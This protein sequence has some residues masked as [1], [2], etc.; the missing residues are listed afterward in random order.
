MSGA[1]LRNINISNVER[2][3][4]CFSKEPDRNGAPALTTD[5]NIGN[6]QK[7]NRSSKRGERHIERPAAG[8]VRPATSVGAGKRGGHSGG[9]AL[10]SRLDAGPFLQTPPRVEAASAAPPERPPRLPT[11]L[12]LKLG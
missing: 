6:D 3:P 11:P 8:P 12:A 1:S 2:F 4:G 9:T 10:A 5:N 7:A